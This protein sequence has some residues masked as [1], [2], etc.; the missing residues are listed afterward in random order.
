MSNLV[1]LALIITKICIFIWLSG[2]PDRQTI[3]SVSD[4]DQEYMYYI[5]CNICVQK[6]SIPFLPF[7]MG[8]N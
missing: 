2:R 3:V 5:L 8:Y 7:S 4:P 6:G 1:S